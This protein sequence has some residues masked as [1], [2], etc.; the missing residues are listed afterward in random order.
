M[1]KLKKYGFKNGYDQVPRCYVLKVRDEI[2][3]ALGLNCD[4]SFYNRLNGKIEP[5][6]SEAEAIEKVF[7]K[8]N[9][10]SI[11]DYENE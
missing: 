6:V 10:S 5:R 11:W 1:K 9:I 8:Y 2:K 3:E 7:R 4:V